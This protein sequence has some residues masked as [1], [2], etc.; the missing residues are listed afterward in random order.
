MLTIYSECNGIYRNRQG[1]ATVRMK[2]LT[3]VAVLVFML[4]VGSVSSAAQVMNVKMCYNDAPDPEINAV[5]EF[6]TNFK[7]FV[8]LGTNG[9]ITITLYP[10]S[11][12]GNEEQRMELVMDGTLEINVAS[13]A[14]I[15]SVYPEIAAAT[16]P[17]MFDSFHAA[18]LFFDNSEYWEMTK[19]EFQVRTGV[20]L[21]EAVEEGGFI[22][23]T[24]NKKEIRQPEDFK[25]MKFRAMD[26]GQLALYKSFGASGTPI[27]WTEVY[28]AL[29]TGVVDG[30]MNPSTYIISGSLYEV[31][32]YM[33]MANIQYSCQWLVIN[34]E[35][36]E[37]LSPEDRY[38][39]KAAAHAANVINR[40]SVEAKED[41]RIQFLLDKG[42][43]IYWPSPEEM[44]MFK[45]FGQP[46]YIEWIE[47]EVGKSYIDAA[48]K[49]A[50]QA[51]REAMIGE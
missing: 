15:M 49:S 27:P 31:Q 40:L 12:L 17:F 18:H 25:G 35:W 41:K 48:L 36:L 22:A 21:L 30:Q 13:N 29:Q 14:G 34:N 10:D 42:M 26:P 19:K 24:N 1:I 37:S 9:R 11:Q 2:G 4:L 23:F 46:A 3:L 32:S 20:A 51:N 43:K 16:I 33:T 38:V 45:E 5:H 44:D 39:I 8:E 47:S 6:A 50:E 7:K 28:M